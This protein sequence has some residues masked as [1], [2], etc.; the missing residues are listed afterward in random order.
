VTTTTTTLTVTVTTTTT[1]TTI[2]T[3]TII[4]GCEIFPDTDNSGDTYK[5]ILN[6]DGTSPDENCRL[7][8]SSELECVAWAFKWNTKI[9][10]LKQTVGA[11]SS[12]TDVSSGKK[13]SQAPVPVP[14]GKSCNEGLKDGVRASCAVCQRYVDGRPGQLDQPCLYVPAIGECFSAGNIADRK[15]EA[16]TDCQTGLRDKST[17]TL[18]NRGSGKYLY[19][20]NGETDSGDYVRH[21]KFKNVDLG[22]TWVV[23]EDKGIYMFMSERSGFNL[24]VDIQKMAQSDQ[25]THR[26]SR[27]DGSEWLVEP[28]NDDG[29]FLIRSVRSG[30]YLHAMEDKEINSND[31]DP[32]QGAR[33][34]QQ[35]STG[36]WSQWQ[37]E[38]VLGY[39]LVKEGR[40]C[41]N[42]MKLLT[43]AVI[44][45]YSCAILVSSDPDC[46]EYF[47]DRYQQDPTY[48]SLGDGG[49][50]DDEGELYSQYRKTGVETLTACQSYCHLPLSH[51]C[52]GV[53][54]VADTGTCCLIRDGNFEA[55][56]D[57]WSSIARSGSGRIKQSN[58]GK[59]GA[60]CYRKSGTP[61]MRCSCLEFGEECKE[62]KAGDTTIWRLKE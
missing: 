52:L 47:Q 1:T 19:V 53:V 18:K 21:T 31:Q 38:R 30:F 14:D 29:R 24:H 57:S 55:P 27:T 10:K 4:S 49:C 45:T 41:E 43:R 3:T 15:L 59:D 51:Y 17:I 62:K 36:S 22:N 34:E 40:E 54:Y 37:L 28:V 9:C 16:D 39:E 20:T 5:Q 58:N 61:S 23:K 50:E 33:V 32:L 6:P 8:C 2:T 26:D 60:I 42:D 48:E 13:C 46:S 44:P 25:V 11:K 35:T 12:R 56:D 7:L